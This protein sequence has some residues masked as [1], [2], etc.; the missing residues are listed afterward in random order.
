MSQNIV[1]CS[2]NFNDNLTNNFVYITLPP[3][4]DRRLA[5]LVKRYARVRNVL[6]SQSP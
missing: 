3:Q 4:N 2:Q 1:I 5:G 6:K